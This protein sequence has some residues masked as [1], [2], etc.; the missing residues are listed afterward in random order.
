MKW[1]RKAANQSSARAQT[2]LGFVY[3]RGHGVPWDLIM[4]YMWADLAAA[5]GHELGAKNRDSYALRMT[6]SEISKAKKL[7][8]E[9]KPKSGRPGATSVGNGGPAIHAGPGKAAP[10]EKSED[11]SPLCRDV[12][13]YEAYMTKTG[14]V[15]RLN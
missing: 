5:Q 3:G 11:A 4:A 6:A 8:Q 9:W 15:C 14:K 2:N 7:A 12:G 1:T 10:T 13:G